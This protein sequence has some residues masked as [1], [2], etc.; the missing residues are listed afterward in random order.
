MNEI[1]SYRN[2]NSAI[3]DLKGEIHNLSRELTEAKLKVKSLSEEI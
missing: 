1:K 2:Q 3:G